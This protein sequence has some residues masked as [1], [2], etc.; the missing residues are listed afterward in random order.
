MALDE[1]GKAEGEAV[2]DDGLSLECEC[3]SQSESLSESEWESECATALCLMMTCHSGL[4]V[5][6]QAD[7][8]IADSTD[9]SFRATS[10]GLSVTS[11]GSYN[12]APK[13][14]T[15]VLLGV[16][17]KGGVKVN[18][19]IVESA[20]VKEEDERVVVDLE[21]GVDVGEVRVEW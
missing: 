15:I 21:E 4:K 17:V 13:L 10:T 19:K 3:N 18:G 20:R 8:Q 5:E 1:E 9:V 6:K 7:Y 14:S 12:G 2:L 11:K 16:K